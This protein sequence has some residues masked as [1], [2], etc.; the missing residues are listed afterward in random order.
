MHNKIPVI[1]LTS[2]HFM[3]TG[4][5]GVLEE[6]LMP[7][8]LMQ[9]GS[10]GEARRLQA[11]SGGELIIVAPENDSPARKARAHSAL[12]QLDWLMTT[13]AM[14]RVPCLVLGKNM[15]ISVAGKT[16]WLTKPHVGI[17]LDIVLGSILA[18]PEMYLDMD[19]WNPLSVKQK[20][21]L[22]GTLSGMTLETL[23]R[24]M[25]IRPRSVFVHRDLLIKRLGLH[26]RLELMC[27]SLADFP[28]L[29][30]ADPMDEYVP[31]LVM[32]GL[33]GIVTEVVRQRCQDGYIIPAVTE[34]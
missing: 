8:Q 4:L 13:G 12:R 23:A 7:M 9:V 11:K 6:A 18:Q 24:Q 34:W 16:F 21:V 25:H 14:Q 31:D 2:C 20:K 26:N 33:S 22:E 3:M 17:Y 28:D 27:L 15:S 30:D 10:V 19:V 29:Q 1:V 5:E 32:N